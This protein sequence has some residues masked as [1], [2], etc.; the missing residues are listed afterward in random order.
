MLTQWWNYQEKRYQTPG[1]DNAEYDN[2]TTKIFYNLFACVPHV[3]ASFIFSYVVIVD[4]RE[5]SVKKGNSKQGGKVD[6][7]FIKV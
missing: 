4:N 3:Y 2:E 5:I 7:R 1:Y 6:A